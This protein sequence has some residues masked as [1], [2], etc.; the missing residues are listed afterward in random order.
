MTQLCD[1]IQFCIQKFI[2]YNFYESCKSKNFNRLDTFKEPGISNNKLFCAINEPQIIYSTLRIIVWIF[3]RRWIFCYMFPKTRISKPRNEFWMSLFVWVEI[4]YFSYFLSVIMAQDHLPKFPAKMMKNLKK[5]PIS[6][7]EKRTQNWFR[8]FGFS[9]LGTFVYDTKSAKYW[10][11][12]EYRTHPLGFPI[13]LVTRFT[14]SPTDK[15][16]ADKK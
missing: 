8:V 6:T 3:R 4:G 2:C 10:K 14:V 9:F 5:W 12:I 16:K 15:N 13:P 11:N 7:H 1:E